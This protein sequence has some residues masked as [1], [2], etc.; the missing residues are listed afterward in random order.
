[1]SPSTN[2]VEHPSQKPERLAW[3]AVAGC[4]HD[5]RLEVKQYITVVRQRAIGIPGTSLIRCTALFH[6]QPSPA[7]WCQTKWCQTCW[8]RCQG[9]GASSANAREVEQRV[10]YVLE[11]CAEGLQT[12]VREL[13]KAGG[14]LT[15]AADPRSLFK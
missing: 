6:R 1:M 9:E 2:F 13:E 3:S 12:S 4:L 7:E 15:A 14:A 5:M 11:R 8:R 10:R